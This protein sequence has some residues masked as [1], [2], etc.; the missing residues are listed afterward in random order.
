[1]QVLN[2]RWQDGSTYTVIFRMTA[3]DLN[4]MVFFGHSRLHIII[5]FGNQPKTLSLNPNQ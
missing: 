1:M 3:M 4:F 5:Q 2:T